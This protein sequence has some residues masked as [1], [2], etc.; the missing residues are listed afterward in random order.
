MAECCLA[1]DGQ[2]YLKVASTRPPGP[3]TSYA[4]PKCFAA[5]T[6]DCSQKISRE[7]YIS[8]NILKRFTNLHISGMPFQKPG[9]IL[10][11]SSSS[12]VANILCER[13]NNALSPLDAT[14]GRAFDVIDQAARHAQKADADNRSRFYLISGDGLE[15]WAL[16]TLLGVYFA[17]I[18]AIASNPVAKTHSVDAEHLVAGLFADE[19]LPPPC[20]LYIHATPGDE[21][22]PD[23]KIA[24]LTPISGAAQLTGLR[25]VFSGLT[26]DLV[27]DF[28]GTGV[29]QVNMAPYFRPTVIDLNHPLRTA[30][31]V[32]T[33]RDRGPNVRRVGV[34]IGRD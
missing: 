26:L 15:R 21:L 4:H 13:H 30:R 16:K 22:R 27:V 6:G 23:F 24:P 34:E 31:I 20:G 9:S 25:L 1:A 2:P 19:M 14:A 29:A 18:A 12:L 7:H 3:P 33:W 17:N 32:A 10:K 11:V 8:E 28:G 5:S